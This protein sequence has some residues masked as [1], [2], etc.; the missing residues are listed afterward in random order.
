MAEERDFYIVPEDWPIKFRCHRCKVELRP[1]DKY[2]MTDDDSW[3][4]CHRCAS[5]RERPQGPRPAV[6]PAHEREPLHKKRTLWEA[7][8]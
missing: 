6:Y 4:L 8:K 3:L 7:V 2:F 5:G 1:G